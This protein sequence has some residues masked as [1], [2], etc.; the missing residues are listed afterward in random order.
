[1]TQLSHNDRVFFEPISHSYTLDGDKLLMGVTE[2]MSKHGINADYAGIKK[3]VLDNAAKEGTAIHHEIQD[4]ENSQAILNSPLIEDYKQLGLKF[5]ESEYP[6]SDFELVASAIDGVYEGSKKNSVILLDYKT[7]QKLHNRALQWQLGLYKNFFERQNPKL[8][9]EACYCLWIDK[10][11]RKI[12]GLVPI[13][14]VSETEVLALLDAE[15]KGLLYEDNYEAPTLDLVLGDDAL[16]YA[17]GLGKVA[18]LKAEV[19]KLEEGLKS[20]DDTIIAYMEEHNLTSI[21][22]AEG[23]ITK[24]AASTSERVD[25]DKLKTKFPHIWDS[26]KKLSYTKASLTFK[27]KE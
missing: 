17:E 24:R 25:T 2:L 12:K 7:T 22:T 20:Y 1:M 13:E 4:Y 8:T 21:D 5:I 10:K 27:P 19:K 15:R 6:V 14:P 18:R 9:V 11:T 3:E 26:V 16:P 23:K